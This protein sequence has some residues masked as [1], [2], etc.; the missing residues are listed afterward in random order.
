MSQRASDSADQDAGRDRNVELAVIAA[1]ADVT[2]H[3]T[4]AEPREPRPD[5]LCDQQ[6]ETE[7]D[8]RTCHGALRL[9]AYL[10]RLRRLEVGGGGWTT[11]NAPEATRRPD[12]R[13]VGGS[14][15]AVRKSG[16]INSVA[17]YNNDLISCT[18]DFGKPTKGRTAC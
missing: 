8:E 17:I 16:M 12:T 7:D 13:N 14:C 10:A 4:E 2:R 11:S 6:H 5:Q 1:D 3:A 15:A 18:D 9:G